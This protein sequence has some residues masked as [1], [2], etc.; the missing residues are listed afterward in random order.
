MVKRFDIKS[1]PILSSVIDDIDNSLDCSRYKQVANKI[2]VYPL[3]EGVF[4]LDENRILAEKGFGN[5]LIKSYN[6]VDY[7]VSII[8]NTQKCEEA[9]L[10]EREIA[11][12]VLHELGHILNEPE[13]RV[14]PTFEYCFINGISFDR[15]VLNEIKE[16][17]SI[18]METYADSYANKHGFGKELISTFHKQNENFEQK[19]GYSS[20][21]IKKILNMEN[22]E[23]RIMKPNKS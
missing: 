22:L 10:T 5:C 18:A 19:I 23:G 8:L 1:N 16:S 3:S 21:R 4:G 6:G 2:E 15:K 12:V 17:N 13:L 11:A 20:I 9:D 7:Y 14:E